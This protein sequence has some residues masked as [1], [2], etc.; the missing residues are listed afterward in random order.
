[1]MRHIVVVAL[2]VLERKKGDRY[3]DRCRTQPHYPLDV[4]GLSD[5]IYGT[6]AKK[7]NILLD[8]FRA[9]KYYLIIEERR[10]T[11]MRNFLL[12]AAG[13]ACLAFAWMCS[14]VGLDVFLF[15]L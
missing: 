13:I 2:V 6:K 12:F 4:M 7:I 10:E 3:L 5:T 1:M 14:T 9:V 8:F 11:N 15:G